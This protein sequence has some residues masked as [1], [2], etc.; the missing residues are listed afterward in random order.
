MIWC[1]GTWVCMDDLTAQN[2]TLWEIEI[3]HAACK[4]AE[5]HAKAALDRAWAEDRR[6]EV[7][8]I[9][10]RARLHLANTERTAALAVRAENA[11]KLATWFVVGHT[12]KRA[13]ETAMLQIRDIIVL[14]VQ[15]GVPLT[16]R[17]HFISNLE[18]AYHGQLQRN[19]LAQLLHAHSKVV[20]SLFPHCFKSNSKKK[21]P[22]GRRGKGT[23]RCEGDQYRGEERA[24]A[25]TDEELIVGSEDEERA[26]VSAGE[27]EVFVSADETLADGGAGESLADVSTDEG[28]ATATVDA[29]EEQVAAGASD[30]RS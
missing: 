11:V 21:R 3:M 6:R 13:L 14:R 23:R 4:F 30:A 29:G 17:A 19:T 5:D 27:E 15:M 2:P 10:M 28:R 1:D 20:G 22:A 18:D 16:S 8:P 7:A 24:A 9:V 12:T 25:V 26:F